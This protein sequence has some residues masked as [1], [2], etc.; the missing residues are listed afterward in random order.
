MYRIIL[1]CK[2]VPPSA[3]APGARAIAEEFTHRPWHENV[4][5]V[6]DGTQLML[7]ADNDFDADGLALVDEFSDA[8]TACIKEGFDGDIEIVSVTSL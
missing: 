2:G 4:S 1:A 7:L 6:W 8:I 3:G 5:C